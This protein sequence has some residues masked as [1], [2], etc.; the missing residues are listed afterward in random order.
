MAKPSTARQPAT[1]AVASSSAPSGLGLAGAGFLRADQLLVARGLSP[2]RSVAARLI[3]AQEV[4]WQGA[5]GWVAVRKAGEVLPV[6]TPMHIRNDAEM[7]WVSRAGLKL[8]AALQHT[9]LRLEGLVGLDVGQSTGGFTEVMLAHGVQGVVG[10]EVGHGQLHPRLRA[11]ARVQ[12]FEGVNAREL[13]AAMLGQACP[14]QGFG[15]MA[16]DVSF[17][18]QTLIWPALSGLLAGGG[19]LLSLVKPQFELQ[20]HDIARGGLVKSEAALQR[21]KDKLLALAQEQG[22]QVL[23]FFDSAITGGDGNREA[24]ILMQRP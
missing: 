14:P 5:S 16:C 21:V 19:H 13:R 11:D 3:Q 2:T 24:F 4:F 18:S 17:I 6:N 8:E 10:V 9:G 22:W 23:D 12:T 20:P 15:F 1:A 7:R